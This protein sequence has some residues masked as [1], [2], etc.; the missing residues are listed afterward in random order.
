MHYETDQQLTDY[1]DAVA[2]QPADPMELVVFNMADAARP[3][4]VT[5]V[6]DEDGVQ[7]FL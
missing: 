7:A 1:R 6:P 4:A 2:T 5:V 3:G